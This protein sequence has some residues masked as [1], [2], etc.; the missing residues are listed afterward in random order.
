MRNDLK[1]EDAHLDGIDTRLIELLYDNARTPVT[2]LARAVGMTAPS[3]NERLRRLEDSGV[4][5]H[6]RVEVNPAALGYG[7]MAI[8]R[9]RQLPG[10]MKELEAQINS[11][12]EIVECDKV[13]GDDCYIARLYLKDISELDP[14]LDSIS[15]LADTNTA[16]VKSTPVKRRLLV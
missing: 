8:V 10:K 6:Y 5:A 9:M 16:I 7:L 12:A 13:T 14:I 3:V 15:E 4:I 1:K 11:I 2:E